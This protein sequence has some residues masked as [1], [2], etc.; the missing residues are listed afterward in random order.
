MSGSAKAGTTAERHT[1]ELRILV[2]TVV[3]APPKRASGEL[4]FSLTKTY[5]DVR[6]CEGRNHRR[7]AQVRAADT[8]EYGGARSSEARVRRTVFFLDKD[9][10]GGRQTLPWDYFRFARNPSRTDAKR[11]DPFL[12][13]NL[14]GVGGVSDVS[15]I[16]HNLKRPLLELRNDGTD[17]RS[18][19][20]FQ[21]Q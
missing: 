11:R 9:L 12:Q 5:M 19:T 3:R 6:F 7:E 17:C 14:P 10:H 2:S 8:G 18:V 20:A 15:V 21:G 1:C 16:Q 13:A 4:C